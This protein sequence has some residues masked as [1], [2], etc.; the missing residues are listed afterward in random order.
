VLDKNWPRRP[1]SYCN[2]KASPYPREHRD[3]VSRGN[4]AARG[5]KFEPVQIVATSVLWKHSEASG[6]NPYPYAP[7]WRIHCGPWCLVDDSA[8]Q[9]LTRSRQ[10]F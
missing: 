4:V 10:Q 7:A 1:F 3:A 6:D 5:T 8:D 9:Q 2:S